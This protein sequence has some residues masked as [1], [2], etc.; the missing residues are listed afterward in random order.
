[1][2]VYRF[3]QLQAWRR[4]RKNV[5]SHP[6]TC[7]CI[8]VSYNKTANINVKKL[9]FNHVL[10]ATRIDLPIESSINGKKVILFSST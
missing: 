7:D 3:A 9:Q 4:L 1:M 5:N 2:Q 10:T 6:V 8:P